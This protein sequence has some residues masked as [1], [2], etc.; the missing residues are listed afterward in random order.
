M[1]R[2]RSI[3]HASGIFIPKSRTRAPPSWRGLV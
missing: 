1:A 3:D 2:P